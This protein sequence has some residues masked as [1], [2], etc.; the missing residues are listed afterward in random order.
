MVTISFCDTFIDLRSSISQTAPILFCLYDPGPVLAS[1][2]FCTDLMP[3]NDLYQPK[4]SP[5]EALIVFLKERLCLKECGFSRNKCVF[6]R[7]P[8]ILVLF[9]V[10]ICYYL[11]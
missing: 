8:L 6:N 2:A 11:F 7:N 1:P 4:E 10:N 9:K 3:T 5:R